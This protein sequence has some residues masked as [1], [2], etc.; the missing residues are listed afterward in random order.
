MQNPEIMKI[1]GKKQKKTWKLIF[2][3]DS[4]FCR[5]VSPV[6]SWT[7]PCLVVDSL[8]LPALFSLASRKHN[9]SNS[10]QLRVQTDTWWPLNL[11]I[12]IARIGMPR[13]TL[14]PCRDTLYRPMHC[15]NKMS[16]RRAGAGTTRV[17]RCKQRSPAVTV[18]LFGLIPVWTIFFA[19]PTSR[20][21]IAGLGPDVAIFFAD[22]KILISRDFGW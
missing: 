13:L 11:P 18:I 7:F 15:R 21:K 1:T 3:F 10:N 9:V 12:V 20:K 8:W 16:A 22:V 14:V 17:L 6:S 5:E 19:N 4:N 2:R